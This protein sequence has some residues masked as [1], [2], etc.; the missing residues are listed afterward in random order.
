MSKMDT[1]LSQN[2]AMASLPRNLLERAGAASLPDTRGAMG[3]NKRAYF[4]VRFQMGISVVTS[5][6]IV[7]KSS[8]IMDK[9]IKAMEYSFAHQLPAGVLSLPFHRS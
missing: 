5:Y 3:N 1:V 7:T 6:G 9:S 4:H 8:A 2:Q